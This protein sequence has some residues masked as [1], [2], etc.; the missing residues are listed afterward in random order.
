MSRANHGKILTSVHQELFFLTKCLIFIL[1][2]KTINVL[3]TFVCAGSLL[4]RGLF[5][6]AASRATL[7]V[8]RG[9]L[10]AVA[11]LVV[12]HE[13]GCSVAC[14]IFLAQGSNPCPLH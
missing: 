1:I 4:L 9:L 8:V 12:A 14:G 6:V 5:L 7:V 3:L 11:S 10:I 13:L 2:K